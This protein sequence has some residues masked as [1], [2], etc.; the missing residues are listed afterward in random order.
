[1]DLNLPA[2]VAAVEEADVLGDGGVLDSDVYKGTVELAYLDAAPSGAKRITIHFNTNGQVNKNT[3]YISNKNGGFTY[4]DKKTGDDMPLPG[5]SQMNAFFMAVTGKGI[6]EQDTSEKMINIYD[7]SAK[8]DKPT[9]V[10]VFNDTLNKPIAIGIMKVSEEKTTADSGYT[11]GTG[12]FREYNEYAKYFDF[13]SGLTVAEKLA[14]TASAVFMTKWR[15]KNQGGLKVK[16][17][18]IPG[19]ATGAVAGAPTA[20]PGA[21]VSDPFA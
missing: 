12:E 15:K 8:V 3:T 16:K 20:S 19:V 13:T 11:Q 5:Y 4:K 17:A 18:K 9:E 21:P 14:G 1:M 2:G 7:F 10:T 6:G